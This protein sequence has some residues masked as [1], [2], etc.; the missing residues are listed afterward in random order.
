MTIGP[1]RA[2]RGL[3]LV[4]G[5]ALLG[6]PP[7]VLAQISE[8]PSESQDTAAAAEVGQVPPTAAAPGPFGRMRFLRLMGSWTRRPG[9]PLRPSAGSGRSFPTRANR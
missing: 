8:R 2:L 3:F 9:W 7:V 4:V 6:A 1:P 5:A